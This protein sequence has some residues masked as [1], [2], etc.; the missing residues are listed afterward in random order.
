MI[1]IL[2][3][4]FVIIFVCNLSSESFTATH[5]IP[6]K[7]F[8]C[9]ADKNNIHPYFLKNINYIKQMNPGWEYTLMDDKDIIEYISTNF[10]PE[11]LFYYNKINPNYGSARADF[12]RYLLMWKEGGAYFDIKS[13]MSVSLDQ[14]IEPNDEYLLAHW[15]DCPQREILGLELG[16]YQQWHIICRPEHP[17]LKAV[18]E[19]VIR[20][21]QSYT[22][23]DGIGKPGVLKVTGP[24]AYSQAIM[25]LRNSEKC[26]EVRVDA[27]LGLIYN[28]LPVEHEHLFSKPHYSL[29]NEPIII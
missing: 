22:I 19:K 7:I 9:V 12:F 13:A 25:S 14:I 10:P 28:N 21:I 15:E 6:K 23:F 27:D 20:N 5:K 16:E 2:I 11:I 17:F 29:I 8:Q 18:I 1:V 24:I 4:L 3:L 26:R